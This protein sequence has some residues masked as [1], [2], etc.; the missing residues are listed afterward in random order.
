MTLLVNEPV[1]NTENE[2]PTTLT[3]LR[4]LLN[5]MMQW[6][7]IP[8]LDK[9]PWAVQFAQTIFGKAVLLAIFALGL[10]LHDK[11]W[12]LEMT[13]L[14]AT[15]TYWPQYRAKLLIVATLY[16]LY[17]NTWFNWDLIRVVAVK[18]GVSDVL[19]WGVIRLNLI[20]AVLL[21]CAAFYALAYVC[22]DH[23]AM[24]RPL[25]V[26]HLLNMSLI[27]IA[28]YAPL[29]PIL[30]TY[31]WA[32]LIVLMRYIWFLGYS[33]LDI[34]AKNSPGFA[35]QIGHYIPFW[36][37][38]ASTPTP[39]PKGAAY[40]RKIEAKTTQ[41]QAVCQLKALKLIYWAAILMVVQT[42]FSNVVYSTRGMLDWQL[43]SVFQLP[44]YKVA[45]HQAIEGHAYP[46]YI[47]WLSLIGALFNNVLYLAVWGHAII[48]V[49][50]MAG[51]NALRGTYKPLLATTIAE[52]WNR[53]FYYFKELLV[54]FFFYPTYLRY[55]KKS[56]RFRLFFATL[57]AAG[58]GN[59]LFHFIRDIEFIIQM[60]F[61]QALVAFHVY[62]FYGLLL[63]TAIG[64]SQLRNRQ[65]RNH[66]GWFRRNVVARV[67]V[68]GFY[69]IVLI[70]DSPD[71]IL[72]L[73]DYFVFV[74]SLVNIRY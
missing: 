45:L 58:F 40:L 21:F 15:M 37:G 43:V 33:L 46:W 8:P 65:A 44:D 71:R 55:F 6:K 17:A 14:L 2:A 35:F 69:C 23:W 67:A 24:R 51:Y 74:F 70:F 53:Y 61:W 32:F 9:Y 49:C 29:S 3:H 16:W 7:I 56:P 36:M 41:E 5:S 18:N 28:C 31:L 47:G 72:S 63:G 25:V 12:W 19:D 64:I 73:S 52:F 34:R 10:Y 38:L 39:M 60:G 13:V 62:M 59:V 54:E 57:A 26:L 50:R 68:I 11:A 20:A 66:H 42:V 4:A 1:I 48:A 27:L 30:R 22:K